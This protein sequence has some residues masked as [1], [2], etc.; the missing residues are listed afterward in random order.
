MKRIVF[1]IVIVLFAVITMPLS[2]ASD[3]KPTVTVEGIRIVAKGYTGQD[4]FRSFLWTEGTTVSLMVFLPEGG[5][6]EFKK[7]GSKLESVTDNKDTDLTKSVKKSAFGTVAGFDAWTSKKSND[8]KAM[9]FDV[10]C[11][12]VPKEGATEIAVKGKIVISLGSKTETVETKDVEI[13]LESKIKA[14]IAEMEISNLGKGWGDYAMS[15]SLKGKGSMSAI[16][17]ISFLDGNGKEI[18][19]NRGGYTAWGEEFTLDYQLKK[20]VD[21]ATVKVEYWTDLKDVEIP[22]NIKTG[23]GIGK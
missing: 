11:P 8:T 2:F 14:G 6:V 4:D 5:I 20:K 17:A 23:I 9:L 1:G 21:K 18:E 13:K 10:V 7:D 19:S 22:V 12:G 16:K 3:E 15:I